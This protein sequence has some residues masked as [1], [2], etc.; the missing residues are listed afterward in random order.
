MNADPKPEPKPEPWPDPDQPPLP[1]PEPGDQP[2]EWR[3]VVDWEGF[4]E[5]SSLGRVRSLD[6]VINMKNS[7]GT[8]SR[9]F[10]RGMILQP[11]LNPDGYLIVTLSKGGFKR[12]FFVHSIVIVS[13]VGPRPEGRQ[14][15]AHKDCNKLNNRATNLAWKTPQANMFDS[16]DFNM[17]AVGERV[18]TAKLTAADVMEIRAAS[19]SLRAQARRFGVSLQTIKLIRNRRTWRHI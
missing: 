7:H 8:V 19:S 18:A 17:Q 14:H 11:H 3:P 16:L 2:E 12:K 4:Y 1:W 5:V 9:H 13:F 10:R 15:C 6:R